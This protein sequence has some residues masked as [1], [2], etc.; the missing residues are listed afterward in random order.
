[1]TQFF[2][3]F[4]AASGFLS[5]LLGAFG[6]HALK[7]RL[8]DYALSVY[9]TGSTYQ[10]THAL[11]LVLVGILLK[12]HPEAR[13]LVVSGWAFIVGTFLF[14]GSL[15]LL[16]FTGISKLGMI[17]PVGGL[18]FLIGW[19]GVFLFAMQKSSG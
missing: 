13:A 15:Y 18:S 10:M 12:S 4:G 8:S 9:T 11:I 16:A 5:V 19:A 7:T 2:L 17:T 6:A 3:A 1:M 14:S